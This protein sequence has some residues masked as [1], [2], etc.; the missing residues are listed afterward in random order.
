MKKLE[1]Q[2]IKTSRMQRALAVAKRPLVKLLTTSLL[3]GSLSGTARAEEKGKITVALNNKTTTLRH[4]PG[5]REKLEALPKVGVTEIKKLEAEMKKDSK[6][7]ADGL[8]SSDRF[9]YLVN[10]RS[11]GLNGLVT[12]CKNSECANGGA[13]KIFNVNL[14]GKSLAKGIDLSLLESYYGKDLNFVKVVV[15]K[16]KDPQ[17]GDYVQFTIIPLDALNGEI[18]EGVPVLDIGYLLSKGK[19]QGDSEPTRRIVADT[20]AKL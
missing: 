3:L 12:I 9:T 1:G 15:E 6:I 18:K 20:L 17:V 14:E 4:D 13:P 16:G 2:G 19:L 7:I 8:D 10:V 11:I 5:I